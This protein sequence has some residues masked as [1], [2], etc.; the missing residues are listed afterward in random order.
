LRIYEEK[1]VMSKN[2]SDAR[3]DAAAI[4]AEVVE[5]GYS[6]GWS[7]DVRIAAAVEA[8]LAPFNIGRNGALWVHVP[9]GSTSADRACMAESR[10]APEAPTWQEPMDRATGRGR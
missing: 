8:K 1:V 7:G 5:L 6:S 9:G 3:K 4:A 2:F 10:S